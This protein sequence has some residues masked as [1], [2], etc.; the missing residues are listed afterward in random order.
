M[1]KCR[2]CL[3]LLGE[4]SCFHHAVSPVHTVDSLA[5]TEAGVV[6]A[7]KTTRPKD[8]IDA[9]GEAYPE[10]KVRPHASCSQ[11]KRLLCLVVLC[12]LLSHRAA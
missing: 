6:Q 8:F 7:R 11:L 2:F 4:H 5:D 3:S 12:F 9:L 10:V 1:A